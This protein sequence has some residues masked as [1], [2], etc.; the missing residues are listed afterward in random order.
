[1]DAEDVAVRLVKVEVVGEHYSITV[2]D[3]LGKM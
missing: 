1:L 3:I 2:V